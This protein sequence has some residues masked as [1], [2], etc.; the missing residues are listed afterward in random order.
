[1]K[2]SAIIIGASSGIG[3]ELCRHLAGRGCR[4]MPDW[5]YAKLS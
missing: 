5:I 1:V 2:P 4:L 3:R